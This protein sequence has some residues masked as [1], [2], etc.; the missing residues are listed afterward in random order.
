M[1]TLADPPR[2]RWTEIFAHPLTQH[3]GNPS[4]RSRV[5]CSESPLPSRWGWA[6]GPISW[7][8]SHRLPRAAPAPRPQ[9]PRRVIGVG[10]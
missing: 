10:V 9:P 8:T 3:E 5:Q 6:G 1:T 7:D 4:W 2:P